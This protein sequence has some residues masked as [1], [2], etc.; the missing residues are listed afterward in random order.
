MADG[1]NG[2]S[3]FLVTGGSGLVGQAIRAVVEA[4]P[5]DNETWHFPT[6]AELDL[7]S[8]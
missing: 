2:G 8:V 1:T 3:V 4:A 7:T 5:V 6:R